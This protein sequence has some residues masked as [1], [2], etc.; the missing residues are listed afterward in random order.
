MK[1]YR[2]Y[3]RNNTSP[4]WRKAKTRTKI[5]TKTKKTPKSSGEKAYLCV[6]G[7][8]AL[9]G[10]SPKKTPVWARIL[11]S[12]QK[13]CTGRTDEQNKKLASSSGFFSKLSWENSWGPRVKMGNTCL[14]WGHSQLCAVRGFHSASD[15]AGLPTCKEC[16]LVWA[17]APGPKPCIFMLITKTSLNLVRLWYDYSILPSN[18]RSYYTVS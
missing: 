16:A 4:F 7:S 11:S 18:K 12:Q 5:K 10:G 3:L 8:R 13:G 2:I 15:R 1:V 6:I 14:P 17:T 9:E